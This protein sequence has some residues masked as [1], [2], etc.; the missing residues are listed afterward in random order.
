MKKLVAMLLT[1]L[2]IISIVSITAYAAIPEQS[3]QCTVVEADLSGENY[4]IYFMGCRGHYENGVVTLYITNTSNKD[5]DFQVAI[6]YSN[7]D[8]EHPTTVESGYV[9][10]K[11][12]ITGKFV[13]ENLA[14]TP[15]KSNDELGYIPNSQLSENSVVRVQARGIKAGDTFIVC[16]FNRYYNLRDTNYAALEVGSVTAVPT[17]YLYINDAKLVI[18]K[19]VKEK[20]SNEYTLMQPPT[21][22]V[23]ALITFTVSSAIV[24]VGGLIIYTVVFI[25]KRR[26]N[27]DRTWKV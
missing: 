17:S 26:Q 23:N 11:P 18:K 3:F 15:E 12:G 2:M 13:L 24:C 20:E 5:I 8:K 16:G 4:Q 6:G 27:D 9:T 14:K 1:I 22:V 25:I 19:E 21:E 10:L 7:S